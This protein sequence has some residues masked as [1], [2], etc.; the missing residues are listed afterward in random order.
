[1]SEEIKNEN[2]GNE[3]IYEKTVEQ[4]MHE[5]MIPFSEYVI[6]DRALPR[7]EDGLKPVQRRILYS[8]YELGLTHDKPHKKCARIVGEC[9]GKYHPHGDT[10]VYDALVRL[11]QDFNMSECLV[12]GHG[13]FGS[14]SKRTSPSRSSRSK[15]F[16]F[17]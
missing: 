3:R 8:M 2:S 1:M 4:V 12:D 6:L 5:S 10:S 17:T 14:V 11:A 7:V 16:M 15:P 13:N 9:L